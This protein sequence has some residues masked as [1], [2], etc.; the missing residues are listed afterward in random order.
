MSNFELLQGD[1]LELMKNIPDKSVDMILCDLPYGTTA[2]KWDNV[3][4]FE[5]LWE[6]Y[7]RIIKQGGIIALFGKEPFSSYLRMSNIKMYKYD[8]IWQKDQAPG[9]LLAEIQPM[10]I[11]ENISVFYQT[12]SDLYDTTN[13]F[14]ELKKYMI[15]E[16]QKTKLTNNELHKLLGNYMFSHYFTKKSQFT[17]PTEK[18][19]KKLQKTGFFKKEY[20]EIKQQYKK[21]REKN[22]LNINTYNPQMKSGKPYNAHKAPSQE[23]YCKNRS[24]TVKENKGTRYPVSVLK[25]KRQRGLHPTQKPVS[26]L[27]Y[28]IKTY[29]NECEM[30]LDNC[31]GSGSTGVACMNT[32]R[33][34]IGIELDKEYFE[35]AKKRIEEACNN[36][37]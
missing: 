15:A 33:N 3:I 10:R 16:R 14:K 21:E 37:D 6:Q 7:K 25:F 19:Y 23:I 31:M 11:H 36:E 1:C 5:P 12:S 9:G 17:I 34:F 30:V 4:P 27:E 22:K 35:I 24:H 13:L 26:L 20:E 2:C 29:T 18:D 8:L 28:L 32:N